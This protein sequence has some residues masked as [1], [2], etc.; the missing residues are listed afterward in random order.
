MQNNRYFRITLVTVMMISGCSS[1][2]QNP[3]LTAAHNSYNTA[4]SNTDVTRL[5][6][7]ELKQAR[8]TLDKADIALKE[9]EDQETVD[10]L[11]YIARKQVEIAQETAE[12][13]TAELAVANATAVRDQ[14]RLD[15]RTAEANAAEEQL[16]ELKAQ[17]TERGL[18]ITLGDV[19][20]R[21]GM[22]QL[23]LGGMRSVEKLA[24][25]LKQHPEYKVSVEGHT[26]N[27]GRHSFNQEL[28]EERA[29]AVETALI[30]MDI[31]SSRISSRGY[32]DEFPVASNSTAAGR[33]MNRRV[34]IIISN[35]KNGIVPR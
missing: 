2:S 30:N 12:Q 26:D 16:R 3:S 35:E 27:T 6:A 1:I 15:A 17:K 20:F 5:A 32:A 19:L 22:A 14:I 33:Q 25:F 8:E 23:E 28:S 29:E 11:A 9:G 18:T 13:K 34:E 31:D 4:L 10:Q 24:D 21:S 7:L